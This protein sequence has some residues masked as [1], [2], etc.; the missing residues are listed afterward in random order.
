MNSNKLYTAGFFLF[1]SVA[2][3]LCKNRSIQKSSEEM[4][5]ARWH[6]TCIQYI[7]NNKGR[8][9]THTYK[10]NTDDYWIFGNSNKSYQYIN[11]TK[12]TASYTLLSAN[13]LLCN[14]DTIH[15]Q[16]LTPHRC[17]LSLKNSNSP[18]PDEK[19]IRMEKL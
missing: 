4:L 9:L 6:I 3:S 11:G 8:S 5:N 19:I 2:L 1:I 7:T 12:Y 15:I 10:N 14:D 16:S 18:I 17:I 13:T